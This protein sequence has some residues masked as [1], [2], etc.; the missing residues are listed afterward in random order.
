[1]MATSCHCCMMLGLKTQEAHSWRRLTSNLFAQATA[2]EMWCSPGFQT[3]ISRP[4]Q[5]IETRTFNRKF[6]ALWNVVLSSKPLAV[7]LLQI[8]DPWNVQ[9]RFY[10]NGGDLFSVAHA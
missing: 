1:M 3:M 4:S 5:A 10:L 9:S 8:L 2:F 6:I 7:W